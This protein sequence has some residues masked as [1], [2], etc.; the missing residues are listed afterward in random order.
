MKPIII[1][2]VAGGG[3]AYATNETVTMNTIDAGGIGK[4]MG[5]LNSRTPELVGS[6]RAW[7]AHRQTPRFRSRQSELRS[8]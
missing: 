3:T 1:A 7:P 5:T 2:I 8:R 4:E 6:R